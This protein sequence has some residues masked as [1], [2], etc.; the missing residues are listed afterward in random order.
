MSG[1]RDDRRPVRPRERGPHPVVVVRWLRAGVLSM[2]ALTALLYLV[3][4]N[5]VGEQVAAAQRTREAVVAIDKARDEAESASDELDE[6][7]S[8]G[9]LELTGPGAEFANATTRVGTLLTSATGG[10][11]AGERGLHHIQFVQGQLTTCVQL[12]NRVVSDGKR[13]VLA[14]REALNDKPEAEGVRADVRFT[15]GLIESLEDLREIESIALAEQ[16]RSRWLNPRLL[17]PLLLA[18]AV[19]ML[20]LIGA[21]DY[22]VARHFR[23]YPHPAL[24]L[25]LLATASVAVTGCLLCRVTPGELT[26][27][28]VLPGEGWVMA[29]TLPLLLAAGVLAYLAYRPRVAEYRFPRS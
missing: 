10:N 12:A 15:G 20:L 16:L 1:V 21:T 3:V 24:G 23:R 13:G 14:A 7:S 6:A 9:A 27:D 17:W 28:P 11:A 22:V 29:I 26:D 25:A 19:V 4:A 2:V 18:P 5:R 8:T